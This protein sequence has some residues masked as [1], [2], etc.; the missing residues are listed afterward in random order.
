MR[1]HWFILSIVFVTVQSD[2]SLK[3]VLEVF[4]SAAGLRIQLVHDALKQVW[5]Q[6][7]STECES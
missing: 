4:Q 3:I 6:I 7:F 1:S 5:Q 2:V